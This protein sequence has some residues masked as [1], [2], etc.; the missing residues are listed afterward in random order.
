MVD[1]SVGGTAVAPVMR[2]AAGAGL[3]SAGSKAK[4]NLSPSKMAA[5][6][7]GAGGGRAGSFSKVTE[8]TPAVEDL[9]R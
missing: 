7:A 8:W 1:L 6:R 9:Y 2:G 4:Q 3:P 5:H